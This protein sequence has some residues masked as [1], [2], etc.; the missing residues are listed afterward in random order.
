MEK[1][2]IKRM[3]SMKDILARYNLFPNRAGFVK[4]P[5]H[6]GDRTASMKVYNDNFHC[7]GCGAD[8]DIFKF[9]MLMDG[10]SFKDAFVSLG[11]NYNKPESRRERQHR[12][13]DIKAAQLK[14]KKKEQRIQEMKKRILELSEEARYC[15]T[16]AHCYVPLSEPW[17]EC[18]EGYMRAMQEYLWLWEEANKNG[19]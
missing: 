18:M 10:L 1:D 12:T 15:R 8:G 14:R 16:F 17:C 5:F 4:C 3:Y 2:E 6:K 7:F 9:V 11:G 13:R 19:N